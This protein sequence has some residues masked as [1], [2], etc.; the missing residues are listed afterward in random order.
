HQLRGM[1]KLRSLGSAAYH[2]VLVARGVARAA[3]LG[4]VRVWDLG[5]AGA[6]L[7]A[8]GGGFEFLD[9]GRVPPGTLLDG[10]RASRDGPAAQPGGPRG[11]RTSPTGRGPALGIRGPA[12]RRGL[13]A[14]TTLLG[15][16]LILFL[17]VRVLP[18][19]P[20]VSI[21]GPK[22]E[23]E[24]LAA[25]RADL[26]LDRPLVVQYGRYLWQLAHGDLGVSYVTGRR[27]G[28]V[29]GEPVPAAALRAVTR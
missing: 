1:S 8:V 9:G 20:A 12:P 28:Q 14:L 24:T 23:P 17:L 6:V 22:A 26:G 2:V 3:L 16:T 21:A 15:T 4:N 18:A 5:A 29:L 13:R 27:V 10:P 19:D 7:G 11:A 25:I